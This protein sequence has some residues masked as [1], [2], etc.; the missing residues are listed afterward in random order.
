MCIVLLSRDLMLLSH[1]Q[2]VADKLGVV[3]LNASDAN[4]A[5]EIVETRSCL[6][7]VIDLRLPNLEIGELVPRLRQAGE[8]VAIIACGPHVHEQSLAAARQAACDVV[9]TRGQFERDAEKI[10]QVLQAKRIL[11]S[12]LS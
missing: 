3:L 4:A 10:L 8:N 7:A 12:G 2:G 11:N 9:V 1:I 6:A 5:T